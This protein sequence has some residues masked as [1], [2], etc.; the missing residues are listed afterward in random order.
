MNLTVFRLRVKDGPPVHKH[1]RPFV[2]YM[3]RNNN[4]KFQKYA[5]SRGII[6]A[7][8]ITVLGATAFENW[9]LIPINFD[10]NDN[11]DDDDD[12]DDEI[13]G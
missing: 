6:I 9:G 10:D 11:D 12:D 3:L 13:N 7:S 1:F 5:F 4:K 2:S 8:A